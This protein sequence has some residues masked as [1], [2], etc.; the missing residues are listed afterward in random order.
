MAR[1]TTYAVDAPERTEIDAMPGLQLLQ[2]GVDWCPHCQRAE[3]PIDIVLGEFPA[4]L[5]RRI[6]D[7][8]GRRL[9]RSFRVKLWPTL[10]LLRDGQEIGRC[11][12][13]VDAA[14]V[15]ELLAGA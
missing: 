4:L 11:V 7:G 8:P 15:R 1:Q 2:F 5:H 12:R 10:I 9:G 6:E 13:P 3:A 14:E